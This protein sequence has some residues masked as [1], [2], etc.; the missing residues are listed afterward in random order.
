MQEQVIIK[1]CAEKQPAMEKFLESLVNIDSKIDNPEGIEQVAHIIGGKLK[2][3]GLDISYIG[4]SGMPTHVY[5]EKKSDDPEAKNLLLIGHMDTVFDKGTAKE[6]PFKIEGDKAYGPGV[7]D[8]KSGI[9]IALHALETLYEEGWNKHNITVFFAGD[10]EA[11]HPETDFKERVMEIA[12]GM[13]AAF[14][15]ETGVDNGDMVVS[16]RGVMYP[17][18]TVEGIAAHSGKDPEKGASAIKELA[19]KILEGYSLDDKERGINFNAGL[20]RGG[21]VAN[22]IAGHAELE[23]DFRFDEAKDKEYIEEKLKEIANK[24]HVK[25]TTTKLTIEENRTFL[26]MEKLSGADELLAVI[27]EQARKVGREVNPITVG[28]GSDSCWT[29]YAGV[30]TICA[31]GGRGGLNHSEKEYLFI[32][33]LTDRTQ[34]LAL[35]LMNL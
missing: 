12:K 14:N 28:S 2:D 5:A 16:R 10:E 11:G 22:G 8:M 27:Q 19:Y 13:D 34:I 35:T 25:G 15:F 23:A 3:I 20:I 32:D 29:T 21:V 24:V 30:P 26:P 6:R 9:T 31:M 33:S 18:F 4:G 1:K 7:A 17:I